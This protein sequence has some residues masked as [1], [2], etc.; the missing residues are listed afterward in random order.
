MITDYERNVRLKIIDFGM[1]EYFRQE[2]GQE[3]LL[4]PCVGIKEY[5]PPEIWLDQKCRGQAFD[6]WMSGIV[7]VKMLSGMTPWKIASAYASFIFY[8]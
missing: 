2:D 6:I 5:L 7:L 3:I 4:D 1:A 8:M